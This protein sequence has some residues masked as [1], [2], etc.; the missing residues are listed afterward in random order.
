MPRLH[1]FSKSATGKSIIDEK[2]EEKRRQ[3]NT[4]HTLTENTRSRK[5]TGMIELLDV[6]VVFCDCTKYQ[7]NMAQTPNS[8]ASDNH[9]TIHSLVA[10]HKLIFMKS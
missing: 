9:T 6:L 1:Y 8:W 2:E 4:N 7:S 10:K 3:E 5:S